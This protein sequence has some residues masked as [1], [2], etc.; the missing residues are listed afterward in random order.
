METEIIKDL[1]I[2]MPGKME[3]DLPKVIKT[4]IEIIRNIGKDNKYAIARYTR[5]NC[6]YEFTYYYNKP[7]FTSFVYHINND[8]CSKLT[9]Q[10]I[11][12]TS[13]DIMLIDYERTL[14]RIESILINK[15]I[16]LEESINSIIK[17]K[18]LLSLKGENIF[19]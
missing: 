10:I 12:Y 1:Y 6:I 18:E 17:Q 14:N 9:N 2:M 19:E 15:K 11:I 3:N 16:E 8:V 5:D 4:D 13:K 7:F